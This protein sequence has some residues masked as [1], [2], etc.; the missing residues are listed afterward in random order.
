MVEMDGLV[1]SF[2][3]KQWSSLQPQLG[4][5]S[6]AEEQSMMGGVS[7]EG[8]VRQNPDM[9]DYRSAHPSMPC[10]PNFFTFRPGPSKD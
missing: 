1:H 8:G 5:Q 6:S 3:Q 7:G 2:I 4:S 9:A 10:F